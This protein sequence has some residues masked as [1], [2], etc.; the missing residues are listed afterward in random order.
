MNLDLG[1]VVELSFDDEANN[2]LQGRCYGTS[3]EQVIELAGA[4]NRALHAEGILSCGKHFP[5]YAGVTV[6]AHHELPVAKRNRT[7]LD[8]AELVPYRQMMP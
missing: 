5:G 2:A 6:D 7:E 4:F 3:P 1:P 8:A